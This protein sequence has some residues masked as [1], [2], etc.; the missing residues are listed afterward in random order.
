[1]LID[2]NGLL[3][4]CVNGQHSFFLMLPWSSQ[5]LSNFQIMLVSNFENFALGFEQTTKGSVQILEYR[6][7]KQDFVTFYVNTYLCQLFLLHKTYFT[8]KC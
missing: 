8:K 6:M 1:M 3:E 5:L 4:Q 2:K 7:L